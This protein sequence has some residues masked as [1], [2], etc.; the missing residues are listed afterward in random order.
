MF[1]HCVLCP[2]VFFSNSPSLTLHFGVLILYIRSMF[3]VSLSLL[4]KFFFF[5]CCDIK[6][7]LED[8]IECLRH[9]IRWNYI[10]RTTVFLLLV[11]WCGENVEEEDIIVTVVPTWIAKRCEINVCGESRRR[12]GKADDA[13][14]R[15]DAYWSARVTWQACAWLFFFF[16]SFSLLLPQSLF[17]F[18]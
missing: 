9:T 8:V 4:L 2:I 1:V 15:Q 5:L 6:L 12:E 13:G 16:F 17:L 14:L 3:F 11:L 18:L 10:N 7:S